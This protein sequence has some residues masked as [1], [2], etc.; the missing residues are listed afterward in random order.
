MFRSMML[1]PISTRFLAIETAR[2]QVY[3]KVNQYALKKLNSFANTMQN[4]PNLDK[5]I[6]LN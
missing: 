3:S 6:P 2:F 1:K 5:P 4:S